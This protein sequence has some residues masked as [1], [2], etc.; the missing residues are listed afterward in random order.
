MPRCAGQNPHLFHGGLA[1]PAERG[2]SC[3]FCATAVDGP[4]PLPSSALFPAAGNRKKNR[5][6]FPVA[7]LFF[8]TILSHC[9][10]Y[11][12]EI[13][14][15]FC[16]TRQRIAHVFFIFKTA[17]AFELYFVQRF[18]QRRKVYNAPAYFHYFGVFYGF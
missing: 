18:Y 16:N 2:H 6:D 3:I 7:V 17:E 13:A 10:H 9:L 14:Y 4:T 12:P 5:E 8:E 1:Q 15:R 11:P